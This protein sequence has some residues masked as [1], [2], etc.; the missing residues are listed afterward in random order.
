M[1]RVEA[2][3]LATEEGWQLQVA[4]IELTNIPGRLADDRLFSGACV[5]RVR[6]HPIPIRTAVPSSEAS[7][8]SE[9]NNRTFGIVADRTAAEIQGG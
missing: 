4:E 2:L 7:R 1:L 6:K 8:A 9:T 3:L 5:K